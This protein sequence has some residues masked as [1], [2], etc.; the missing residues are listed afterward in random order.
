M[1]KRTFL[2]PQDISFFNQ[3]EDLGSKA[4]LFKELLV[5]FFKS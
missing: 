5:K 3:Q 4:L 1:L 2:R